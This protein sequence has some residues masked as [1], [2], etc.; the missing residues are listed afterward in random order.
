[1]IRSFVNAVWDRWANLHPFVRFFIASL[2]AALI[3]WFA[4]KP[5]YRVFKG[6][7]LEKNLSDAKKAVDA[8]RMDEARDLSLTV[9][10]SGDPRIEA[11]RILET[12]MGSLRDPRH[13]DI[14]RALISHPDGSDTDRLNGFR[15]MASE[16]P[17]GL[18][19]QAWA[20]LP[21]NCRALPD[22]AVI[23]ADRLITGKRFNEAASVLLGVPEAA[24]T[25]AVDQ[26]L[27][28]V[29]IGSGKRDG[30]DEGQRWISS[31]WPANGEGVAGWL[32]VLEEIP[33]LSLSPEL[34]K[35]ASAA[36]AAPGAVDPPR[37]A[38]ALARLEYV[39]NYASRAGVLERTVARWKDEAPA[40]LAKFLQDLGLHRLLVETFP[41]EQAVR[42]E[43]FPFLL[44]SLERMGEWEKVKLLLEAN[45]D[46]LPKF[47]WLA[48]R[49]L[50]AAKLDDMAASVRDWNEA[51]GEA[52]SARPSAS[53]LKLSQIA[54]GLGRNA[55]AGQ[56]MLEAIRVGRGQLPLYE[57]LKFLLNDLA[58]Q[59]RENELMQI[60]A[61]YLPFESGNPTLLTQYA[62]M[63]CLNGLAD[64]TLIIKAVKPMAENFPEALPIQCVLA[65][66]YL[67]NSEP[68]AAIGVLERLKVD[69]AQLAP[70]YRAAFYTTQVLNRKMAKDDPKIVDFPWKSLLPSERRRFTEWIRG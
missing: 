31:K 66:A 64:A 61:I 53:F 21:A 13:G 59:G 48:H 65:T 57:E 12:S 43:L 22:F 11:F 3:G 28:R 44:A 29:L 62:Y 33:V 18:M 5:S 41:G 34:L 19:G 42:P 37:N 7:R 46:K 56:A 55:E 4:L 15:G 1:M 69:P 70:P 25:A 52:R 51:I 14:A 54:L 32:D 36:L 27:V 8:V 68:A 67:S 40:T 50:A 10:Q 58:A 9:L 24:R 6:W 60:C 30:F 49:A 47:E 26:R 39:A 35:R 45:Q 20:T 23:F 38:L 2:V 17:M 16:A 63:A